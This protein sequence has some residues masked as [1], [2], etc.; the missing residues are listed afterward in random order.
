MLAC[1]R[2]CHE[3]HSNQL[4]CLQFFT[5]ILPTLSQRSRFQVQ[6]LVS[7][8]QYGVNKLYFEFATPSNH[9][10]IQ[11]SLENSFVWAKDSVSSLQILAF[12][13]AQQSFLFQNQ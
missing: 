2:V 10:L 8:L 3:A 1:K 13:R 11:Y 4:G 9:F 6:L 7:M 5:E 12:T